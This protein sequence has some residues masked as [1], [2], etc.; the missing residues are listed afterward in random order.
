MSFKKAGNPRRLPVTASLSL[1]PLCETPL[2]HP[3]CFC[4]IAYLCHT[5][6]SYVQTGGTSRPLSCLH[7]RLCPSRCLRQVAPVGGKLKHHHV[8]PE[9]AASF[10]DQLLP[11]QFGSG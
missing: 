4:H 1:R 3:C 5:F 2:P 11:L 10:D 8:L 6:L 7:Y 9:P